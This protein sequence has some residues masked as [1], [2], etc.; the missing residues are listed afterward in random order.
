MAFIFFKM[1]EDKKTQGNNGSSQI[2]GNY[3]KKC[4]FRNQERKH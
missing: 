3:A 4:N 2:T 1:F